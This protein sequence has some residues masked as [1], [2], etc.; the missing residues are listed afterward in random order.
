RHA[1]AV[2]HKSF[3]A[4]PITVIHSA[5][6]GNA[7]VRFVRKKLIVLR[8]V[9]E[10]RGW[11]LARQT[12]TEVAGIIFDAVAIADRSHHFNVEERTLRQTL[13]FDKFPL[14]LE[15]FFPPAK[16]FLDGDDGALTLILRHGVVRFRVDGNTRQILLARANLSS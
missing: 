11:R 6:L 5:N 15:F 2:V 14:L 8:N 16:L 12:T 13:R 10:Q 7:L 3:L 4:R 1:E 9:I